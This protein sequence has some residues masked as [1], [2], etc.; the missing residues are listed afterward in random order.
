[1]QHGRLTVRSSDEVAGCI[2]GFGTSE[3]AQGPTV[4][5]R[6]PPGGGSAEDEWARRLVEEIREFAR[7]A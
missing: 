3:V 6:I 7:D 4:A 1:M 5:T 2:G